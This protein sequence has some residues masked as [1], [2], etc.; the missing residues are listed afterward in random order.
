MSRSGYSDDVWYDGPEDIGKHNLYRASVNRAFNGKRGQKFFKDLLVALE[1]MPVK[2]L[3]DETLVAEGKFC[4]LGVICNAKGVD[5]NKI[6][7][8]DHKLL[9][10]ELDIAECLSREVVWEN[11]DAGPYNETD[12]QRWE[13]VHGWVKEQIRLEPV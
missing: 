10:K 9:A 3:I 1:A 12:A 4:T 2:E 8:E 13:R 11:D 5:L 7:D 6:N